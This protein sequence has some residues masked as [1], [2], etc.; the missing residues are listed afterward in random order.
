[1]PRGDRTGPNRLGPLTG[2]GAGFCAGFR[3]PG[4]ANNG[5]R[6]FRFSTRGR[7]RGF[8]RMF[9]LTGIA[10]GCAYAAYTLANRKKK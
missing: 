1:M 5:T 10:S 9:C 2:R 7:G 4:S 6:G 3:K 8:G